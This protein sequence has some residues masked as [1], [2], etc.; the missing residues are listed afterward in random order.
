MTRGKT[1][2]EA[3]IGHIPDENDRAYLWFHGWW[4]EA[5]KKDDPEPWELFRV[6]LYAVESGEFAI[7]H[8]TMSEI[9]R[10]SGYEL[11]LRRRRQGRNN[12]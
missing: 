4:E 7:S 9:L 8:R 1:D 11:V 5:E 6:A 3:E 12:L 10:A 2:D